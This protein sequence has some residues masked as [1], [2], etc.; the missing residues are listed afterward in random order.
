MFVTLASVQEGILGPQVHTQLLNGQQ[1]QCGERHSGNRT[2][3][4][5]LE[6][7]ASEP[8]TQLSQQVEEHE[9]RGQQVAAAPGGVDIVP[10]LTPLE[11]H[12]DAI[13]Q[14]G[15]NQAEACHMRQVLLGDS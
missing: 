2:P 6:R 14:E 12:A 9:G 4:S 3:R 15:A 13:L 10:L 11:P 5:I 8:L 7:G 1:P